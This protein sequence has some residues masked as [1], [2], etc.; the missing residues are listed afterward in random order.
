M[1]P[2]NWSFPVPQKEGDNEFKGNHT[3]VMK[4]KMLEVPSSR[5]RVRKIVLY[6]QEGILD[7]S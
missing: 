6:L 1:T 5:K 2:H 4:A 3:G 7:N